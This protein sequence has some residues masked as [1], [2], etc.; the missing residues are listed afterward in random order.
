VDF[1]AIFLVVSVFHRSISDELFLYRLPLMSSLL[2]DLS[3]RASQKLPGLPLLTWI[4]TG[5][6]GARV[7]LS[8][9]RLVVSCPNHSLWHLACMPEERGG[10]ALTPLVLVPSRS[11][12]N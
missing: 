10:V 6:A 12:T 11:I 2:A 3:S 4:A 1:L 5:D 7:K 9:T 8:S